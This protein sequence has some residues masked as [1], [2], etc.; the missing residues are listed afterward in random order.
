MMNPDEFALLTDTDRMN[1]CD[2]AWFLK[3]FEHSD[4]NHFGSDHQ[5]TLEKCI[6]AISQKVRKE[7][8]NPCRPTINDI[9]DKL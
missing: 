1:L 9:C 2:I 7:R 4:K 6:R 5:A 3:G 8:V